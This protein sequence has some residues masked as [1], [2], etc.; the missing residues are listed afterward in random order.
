VMREGA[1]NDA[2]ASLIMPLKSEF[3]VSMNP[4]YSICEPRGIEGGEVSPLAAKPYGFSA[5]PLPRGSAPKT[6]VQLA[7]SN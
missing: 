2:S 4:S 3:N 6:P 1:L 5:T 7:M